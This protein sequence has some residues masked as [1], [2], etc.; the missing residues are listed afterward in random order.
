MVGSNMRVNKLLLACFSFFSWFSSVHFLWRAAKN[1]V[2]RYQ[3]VV[4]VRYM[5]M[6]EWVCLCF[7]NPFWSQN[8]KPKGHQPLWRGRLGPQDMVLAGLILLKEG[9]RGYEEEGALFIIWV[10]VKI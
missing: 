9:A 5:L 8:R 7:G 3:E 1:K 4:K 10:R 6:R 2:V